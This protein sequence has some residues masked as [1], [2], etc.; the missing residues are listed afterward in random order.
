MG[1]LDSVALCSSVYTETMHGM[2]KMEIGRRGSRRAGSGKCGL[3]MHDGELLKP[4]T[5]NERGLLC[6]DAGK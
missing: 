4:E 2:S 1:T 5:G 3:Q 6:P